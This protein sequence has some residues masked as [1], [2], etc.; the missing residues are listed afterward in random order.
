MKKKP[1]NRVRI[2]EVGPRDGLQNE[3][4]FRFLEESEL[5][6]ARAEFVIALADSGLRDVEAGAFV[7]TDRIPQMLGTGKVLA[8]IRETRP[9][10]W[11]S[12]RF[13]CLVPNPKGMELAIAAGAKDIA[14][15]TSTSD[16]FSARNINM[17]VKESLSGISEVMKIAHQK[18]IRV[19]AYISTVWGCP[20]LG[21]T[22]PKRALSIAKQLLDQGAEEISLGDTIGVA[23]PDGV[24]SV[25][26][27]FSAA[28]PIAVH[29][30]DTRGTALANTLRALEL[31]IRTVDSSAGGLGGCPY[32][33]G[34]AGNLATEDLLY[35]LNG[36]KFKTGVN[37]DQVCAAGEVLA[38]KLELSLPS[39]YHRAWKANKAAVKKGPAP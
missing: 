35:M 27:L 6:K 20:Y 17:S 28:M 15:F 3:A 8:H 18:K 16:A 26:R 37:L 39:R 24:E 36:M 4:R 10:L 9:D 38:E 1:S 5:V 22:S 33:R 2:V 23:N 19:R 30:H 14:V 31:G 12:R 7:R 29:F 13:G 11:K 25:L 32:A 34:A 21:K